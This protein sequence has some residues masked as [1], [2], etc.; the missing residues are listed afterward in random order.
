MSGDKK[1]SIL[2]VDDESA[3]ISTLKTILNSEYTI[4]ASINGEEAIEAVE[5][6]MPDVILLDIIMPGMDGYEIITALKKSEKTKDIPVIF[7][8]GLDSADAEEKGL[9]LGAADYITKPFHTAIVKIRVKNQINLIERFRIEHDLNVVLKLQ[10]ELV[11]AK[12]LAERNREIA[13]HSNRVKSEFLSRMSHEMRTPMHAIT[14]VMHIINMHNVPESL[15]EFIDE[16]KKASDNLQNMIDDV[17]DISNMEY[18]AFK[19]SNTVFDADALFMDVLQTASYNA[20]KK[21]QIF[22]SKQDPT[23]P[24]FLNGDE[25]RLKQV[26]TSLLA[27]AVKFTPEK[28]EIFFESE[29]INFDNGIITLQITISDNGIGIAKEQQ[30]KL[31]ELFEQG[32]GSTSRKHFG[33]GI[34]LPLSKRIIEMM[35]GK[36]WVES[37]PEKGATFNFT[38]KLQKVS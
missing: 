7:I 38:C 29:V 37:E 35:D 36:L 20:E 10:S 1:Y 22:K 12:E 15:K 11:S 4:Y 34:G 3:N 6:F 24:S 8:T 21:Q 9:A 33:I 27:N 19:L 16:M 28:G 13:E 5:E 30:D 25:K 17:L 31:F 32:D 2:I 18:G 23:L 26:I 14:S